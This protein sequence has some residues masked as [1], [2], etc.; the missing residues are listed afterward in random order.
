[1]SHGTL[2]YALADLTGRTVEHHHLD[3]PDTAARAASLQLFKQLVLDLRDEA[4]VAAAYQPVPGQVL[5]RG[6]GLLVG[7]AY[8][9]EEVAFFEPGEN[10]VNPRGGPIHV[11]GIV[12]LEPSPTSVHLVRLR[13]A[14]A[15]L[16]A[17]TAAPASNTLAALGGAVGSGSGNASDD[18]GV[19]GDAGRS[20][21][22]DSSRRR[23][24]M[25]SDDSDND[26]GNAR[27]RGGTADSK[28]S[29]S[30]A[31]AVVKSGAAQPA[32]MGG[33][34][35]CGAWRPAQSPWRGSWAAGDAAWDR[36]P[37]IRDALKPERLAERTHA[38]SFWMS[39]EDFCRFFNRVASA[40]SPAALSLTVF[41]GEW[42][43]VRSERPWSLLFCV[44]SL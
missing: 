35:G 39:W 18:R 40:P 7:Q 1:L 20:G 15:E 13:S 34:G 3:D 32:S 38:A 23:S 14:W 44:V 25:D 37:E 29:S 11:Q 4:V 36:Y 16:E 22:E 30:T 31:A 26:G 2:D 24:S 41:K 33:G 21:S 8:A 6:E 10:G 12:D 27:G 17:L 5:R 43:Q 42:S 9:V 19:A 28:R